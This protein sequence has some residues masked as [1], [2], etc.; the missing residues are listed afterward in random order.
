[1]INKR[2]SISSERLWTRLMLMAEIGATTAGGCNR[3]A[4]TDEDAAGHSE[5]ERIGHLGPNKPRRPVKAAFELHIEQGPILESEGLDVGVVTGVQHMSRYRIYIRG[6]ETHAA[7]GAN[8]LLDAI[9]EC[10]LA[11][12]G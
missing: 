2:P 11:D 7:A 4:L 5:L 12:A 1:M 9:M 10:S 3:Q 6:Q 8:I